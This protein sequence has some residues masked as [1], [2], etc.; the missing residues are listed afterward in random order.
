VLGGWAAEGGAG[1]AG[2]ADTQGLEA[3]IALDDVYVDDYDVSVTRARRLAEETPGGC[4]AKK[5]PPGSYYFRSVRYLDRY[6][7]RY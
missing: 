2:G 5:A 7:G 6:S 3:S 4:C 1:A